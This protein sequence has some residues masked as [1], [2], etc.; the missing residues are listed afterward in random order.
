[1]YRAMKDIQGRTVSL[2]LLAGLHA[3]LGVRGVLGGGQFILDPSGG[4]IGVSPSILAG[5]PVSDFLLPGIVLV[6][7]FG[8]FP[9]GVAYGL[10]RGYDRAWMAS[11]VVAFGLLA[12]VLFEGVLMGFSERLQYPN[13]AQ[14]VV[15]L[16]L[17]LA[18]SVRNP[19]E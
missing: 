2:W 4:T 15:M 11:A 18:P 16:L 5:V 12:W 10:Y 8:V 1:M 17:S 3:F 6:F 7:G 13:G 9:L 19:Q 14:A